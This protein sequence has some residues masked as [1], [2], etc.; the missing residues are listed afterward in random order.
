MATPG[1]RMEQDELRGL[2]PRGRVRSGLPSRGG[3]L[4]LLTPGTQ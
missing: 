3:G 1:G 4:R 2:L